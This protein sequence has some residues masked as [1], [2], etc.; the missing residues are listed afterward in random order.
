[1]HFL[2]IRHRSRYQRISSGYFK[3]E[4]IEFA[5]SHIVRITKHS[6]AVRASISLPARHNSGKQ[7]SRPQILLNQ[8]PSP[9]FIFDSSGDC[10]TLLRYLCYFYYLIVLVISFV[11]R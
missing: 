4:V 2:L 7:A 8:L 10:S 6:Q 9:H 1:M 3:S 11:I 5:F